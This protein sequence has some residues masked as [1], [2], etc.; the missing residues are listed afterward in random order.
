MCGTPKL[1]LAYFCKV[2]LVSGVSLISVVESHGHS[3]QGEHMYCGTVL[4]APVC[5]IHDVRRRG[6]GLVEG[7][8]HFQRYTNCLILYF[9]QH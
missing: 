2:S 6:F 1:C 3:F 8:L 5:I 7:A 9:L 4:F